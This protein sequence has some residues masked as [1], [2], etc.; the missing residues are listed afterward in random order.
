MT[1]YPFFRFF[2]ALLWVNQV[3]AGWKIGELQGRAD[4]L[5]PGAPTWMPLDTA[6]IVGHN[7]RLRTHHRTAVRLQNDDAQLRMGEETAIL[8]AHSMQRPH[9]LTVT[10]WDG[11][12]TVK[13]A[14]GVQNFSL[15]C[16]SHRLLVSNAVLQSTCNREKADLLVDLRMGQATILI[17]GGSTLALTAPA[18]WRIHASENKGWVQEVVEP[19][20]RDTLLLPRDPQK[21]QVELQKIVDNT[22]ILGRWQLGK[23]VEQ[24]LRKLLNAEKVKSDIPNNLEAEWLLQV[25]V[26][27]FEMVAEGANRRLRVEIELEWQNR[28]LELQGGRWI[29]QRDWL[30]EDIDRVDLLVRLPWNPAHE[31]M[32]KVLQPLTQALDSLS[33]A[34]LLDPFA[35]SGMVLQ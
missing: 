25:T 24:H 16:A 33:A 29:F 26:Q 34:V 12:L 20:R 19:S 2:L 22:P 23:I 18:I 8:L 3:F 14:Q 17:Q 32:G 31:R 5:I 7:T 11:A 4:I 27:R 6:Q 9:D 15:H 21:V 35:R 28:F 1:L 10:E 13:Q 30:L